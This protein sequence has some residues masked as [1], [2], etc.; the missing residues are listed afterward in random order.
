ME[1]GLVVPEASGAKE[2]SAEGAA[3]T[4]LPEGTSPPQQAF[5]LQEQKQTDTPA[6]DSI[7]SLPAVQPVNPE[8][9]DLQAVGASGVV[10]GGASGVSLG[11]G[12][13]PTGPSVELNHWTQLAQELGVEVP[14]E[15]HRPASHRPET[16]GPPA[17]QKP[18]PVQ[19]ALPQKMVP[20]GVPSGRP[21]SEPV[22][23]PPKE[24]RSFEHPRPTTQRTPSTEPK[25]ESVSR[26]S[27]SEARKKKR[28][29]TKG[30]EKIA[31]RPRHRQVEVVSAEQA[32]WL[33]PEEP[34]EQGMEKIPEASAEPAEGGLA[35]QPLPAQ[36]GPE[37]QSALPTQIEP[38]ASTEIEP[39][40]H[41]MV[42][43]SGKATE[44]GLGL[45]WE[46]AR[47]EG[48]DIFSSKTELSQPDAETSLWGPEN[49]QVLPTK[50]PAPPPEPIPFGASEV[51]LKESV[52]EAAGQ[53]ESHF[54][55]P[56]GEPTSDLAASG[57]PPAGSGEPETAD[58]PEA[59]AELV[60]RAET[61]SAGLDFLEPPSPAFLEPEELLEP[62]DLFE[63]SELE[64]AE[65]TE[66]ETGLATEG[67]SKAES[68]SD[69]QAQLHRA[70]PT[71]K[72]VMDLIIS[73]NLQ[74]RARR[75]DRPP[76]G[77]A[78]PTRPGH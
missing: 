24:K 7:G 45:G 10:P 35:V 9:K 17:V 59:P 40:P 18:A 53:T 64:E 16:P 33:P 43:V 78:G 30:R 47:P 74:A 1:L 11:K 39:A 72:E 42:P 21:A 15:M 23:S 62:E 56:P 44:P 41:S 70:V 67:L 48:V 54:E 68:T 34:S 13:A 50:E 71:W 25:G 2:A 6:E 52:L 26:H 75:G 57:L 77:R 49:Q 5:P 31:R 22:G 3:G 19:A 65:E 38:A 4:T 36:P 55:T 63:P 12:T 20:P 28:H 46:L 8:Q 66:S 76:H 69:Q 29:R 58:L 14:P 61:S 73:A 37:I 51:G 60:P 27:R 32:V